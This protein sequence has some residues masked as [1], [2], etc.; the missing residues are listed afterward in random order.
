MIEEILDHWPWSWSPIKK[1]IPWRLSHA[2]PNSPNI[3]VMLRFRALYH[4]TSNESLAFSGVHT[5]VWV[6]VCSKKIQVMSGIFQSYTMRK[7]CITILFHAIENTVAR[8][9]GLV[10]YW[11][12]WLPVFWLAGFSMAWHKN[13]YISSST[14]TPL[15]PWGNFYV[16]QF[17][18]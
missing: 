13:Y 15:D 12:I 6:S 8:W 16:K 1:Y 9:E 17:F 5:I 3:L 10:E 11:Q 14:C 18:F 4:G 7:G 2:I